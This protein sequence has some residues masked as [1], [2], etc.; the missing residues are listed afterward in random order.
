MKLLSGHQ[1]L[2]CQICKALGPALWQIPA[3]NN[4]WPWFFTVPTIL[5]GCRI[6]AGCWPDSQSTFC[7][8]QGHYTQPW[9]P[10]VLPLT[11]C[12]LSR[13]ESRNTHH[14]WMLQTQAHKPWMG[15]QPLI[16]S[17]TYSVLQVPE[18]ISAHERFPYNQS[19]PRKK[20]SFQVQHNSLFISRGTSHCSSPDTNRALAPHM[21][22]FTACI[23]SNFRKRT[24]FTVTM[25]REKSPRHIPI[26]MWIPTAISCCPCLSFPAVKGTQLKDLTFL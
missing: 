23:K 18:L 5:A 16:L 19:A 3:P 24:G 25:G 14:L 1:L 13:T 10:A 7:P 20:S 8:E 2:Q 26:G 21:H 4:L 9:F 15:H 22:S 6:P 11:S 12:S 17:Q